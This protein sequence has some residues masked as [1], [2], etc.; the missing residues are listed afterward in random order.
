MINLLSQI[1]LTTWLF[2]ASLIIALIIYLF[3]LDKKI[4]FYFAKKKK[5]WAVRA[6]YRLKD[7]LETR[8]LKDKQKRLDKYI[9]RADELSFANNGRRFYVI[10]HKEDFVILDS[11]YAKKWIREHNLN[12]NMILASKCV[13][14]T[15]ETNLC[16]NNK[17]SVRVTWFDS[18]ISGLKILLRRIRFN[19]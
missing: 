16:K 18:W 17:S 4:I 10:D 14:Y 9:K 12:V 6:V 13:Y 1:T 7:E 3:K 11:T 5:P 8:K 19:A 2:I 15:P